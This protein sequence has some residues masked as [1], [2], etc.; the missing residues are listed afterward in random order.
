LIAGVVGMEKVFGSEARQQPA[1]VIRIAENRVE[2]DYAIKGAAGPDR[3]VDRLPNCFFG[4]RV[5]ARNVYALKR[6]DRGANQFDPA[7]MSAGNQLAVR[8]YQVLCRADV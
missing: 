8:E 6:I 7:G 5:V 1:G 2:I 4:F 3:L